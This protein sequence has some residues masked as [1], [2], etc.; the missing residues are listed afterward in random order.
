MFEGKTLEEM[1][2]IA[3]DLQ[4]ENES[5]AS[6]NE[7]LKNQVEQLNSVIANASTG[8]PAVS[9]QEESVPTIPTEP[10]EFE[11]KQ[12]KWL[13]GRFRLIGDPKAYTAQEAMAT[14]EILKKLLAVKGQSIVEELA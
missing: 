6:E 4:K 13:K 14:P 9:K 10:F 3:T 11:G 12:Y 1:I 8:A 7:G 5:L 2:V